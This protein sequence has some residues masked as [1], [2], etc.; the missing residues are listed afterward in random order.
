MQKKLFDPSISSKTCWS[1]L[2]RFLTGKK[3]P[4][5]YPVFHENKFITDVLLLLLLSKQIYY[6]LLTKVELL[7]F[8]FANQCSLIKS[9]IEFPT[10]QK[11]LTDKSSSNITFTDNDFAKIIQGLDLNK[12]HGYDISIRMLN[13]CGGSIYKLLRLIFRACLDQEIFPLCRKKTTLSIT[14]TVNK[15]L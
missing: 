10:D 6:L 15:E 14:Q 12:A 13:H 2:K 7:N 5:I 8:F 4:S 1:I 9:N 11:N 3:V